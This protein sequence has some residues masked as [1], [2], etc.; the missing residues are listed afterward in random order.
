MSTLIAGGTVV[1]VDPENT[2]IEDGAVLVKGERIAA[3]GETDALAAAYDADETVDASGKAVI[4]GLVNL[5]MHSGYIRGLAEDLPVFEWLAEHVDPTHRA[6]TREDARIAYELCYAETASAGITTVLD[7][8]RYMDEAADVVEEYGLRAVLS[9]YVADAEGYDYFESL[10]DNV[11]L[12][13]ERHDTADGRVKVWF[14][15]EHLTYCTEEAYRTV[16]EYAETYD[17]GIHTHGEESVEM[18]Q[19]ITE[20]RGMRPVEAFDDYGILGEKTVLA[21]CVW[22]TNREIELLAET[23]T[24]VAHC[25]TSNE[26][27][28]SGV[29]P[30]PKLLNHGVTVGL[31]TDGIKENNRLDVIQEAKNAALLQKVHNLD[32]TAVP[33]ERALRMATMGGAEALGLEDEIGSLEAGKQ[34]DIVL[35]DTESLHM[36]PSLGAENVVANLVHAATPGDVI[37]VFCAGERVVSDGEFLPADTEELVAAHTEQGADLVER[38]D[39]EEWA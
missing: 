34:A 17:V 8:Y 16:A 36:S 13:E 11:A 3:V 37:E 19:S 28:A 31:G 38:R 30:V 7:M 25:P 18:A 29:A 27:L 9:P 5:H 12:V 24:S 23:G 21:H 6:L 14:A 39:S 33:A 4:P 20:E 35:V 1:T 22:L 2:V 10:E 32:A 26:K 15:L